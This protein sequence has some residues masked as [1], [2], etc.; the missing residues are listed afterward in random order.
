MIRV[1][2]A[3]ALA[4]SVLWVVAVADAG[5][6]RVGRA[7]TDC[8]GGCNFHDLNSN[9]EGLGITAAML[10]LEVLPGDTVLVYPDGGLDYTG[11]V[12]MKSGV[13]L[14]SASGPAVTTIRGNAGSEAALFFVATDGISEV[15]GFTISWGAGEEG[16]GG[17]V[18]AWVSSGK[19]RDNIF[20]ANTA[21]QGSAIYMQTCDMLVENNLFI[22]NDTSA[23]AGTVAISGG[24]PTLRNN[25][26]SANFTPFGFE[27]ATLYGTGSSFVFERNIVHGS[28]GA[29][30]LFCGSGNTPTISCNLFWDNPL[31][32]FAG[33]CVDSVGTSG[34][35]S[36][37]PLFCNVGT[38][39]YGLCADSP[40]LT[41]PCGP[42]GYLPPTGNCGPCGP[43]PS[44]LA[45]STWGQIKALYR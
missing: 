23:G 6:W 24:V 34:N 27:G 38:S 15:R 17:G 36:G 39:D 4:G 41:A 1:R 35:I 5:T 10:S 12:D 22:L 33:Q 37:D 18:A 45:A 30:A 13:V 42:I 43:P 20:I 14:L 8:P 3:V 40:A 44:A 2:G 9:G 26:F 29:A 7:P 25:T 11:K 32:A 21:G 16:L 28:R 19:I 31:G